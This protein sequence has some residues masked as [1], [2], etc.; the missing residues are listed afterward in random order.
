[1]KKFFVIAMACI[2]IFGFSA[3]ASAQGFEA[4]AK[5]GYQTLNGDKGDALDGA[6]AGGLFL[7]YVFSPNVTLQGEW[8]W[9]RHKTSDDASAIANLLT[10]VEFGA[11]T[12]ADIRLTMN[13]FDINAYYRFPLERVTPFLLAGV[14]LDYWK[15]DGKAIQGQF[16][17][18]TDE[19]F[20]DFGVNIGAGLDFTVT[21]QIKLGGEAI[22]SYIFDEFDDS[23]WN[24]FVTGS[25]GFSTGM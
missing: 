19:S 2:T 16:A 9:S 17:A 6:F 25:Y 11:P 8:M 23:L 15:L 14:G 5:L 1:V 7:N 18:K 3:A 24:F 21:E 4:G 13:Q 12:L 22:Y 10:S 20:W